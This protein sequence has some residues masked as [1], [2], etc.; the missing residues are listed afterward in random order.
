M[1]SAVEGSIQDFPFA[2]FSQWHIG[3]IIKGINRSDVRNNRNGNHTKHFNNIS[4]FYNTVRSFSSVN[5]LSRTSTDM[6]QAPR[7]LLK[8][9]T[10]TQ[11]ILNSI[12]GANLTPDNELSPRLPGTVLV[13]EMWSGNTGWPAAWEVAVGI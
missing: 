1:N 7:L 9:E 13:L 5:H 10:D 12:M 6:G 11:L 8:V 2:I 3:C 4:A